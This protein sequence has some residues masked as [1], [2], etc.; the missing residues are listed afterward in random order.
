MSKEFNLGNYARK[1][2]RL[3]SKNIKPEEKSG[4]CEEFTKEQLKIAESV[5]LMMND[6]T[7][8]IIGKPIAISSDEVGNWQFNPDVNEVDRKVLSDF[9]HKGIHIGEGL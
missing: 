5:R 7:K 3:D 8:K 1:F 6:F 9:L 2:L 4:N